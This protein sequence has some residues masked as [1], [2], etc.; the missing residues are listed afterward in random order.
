MKRWALSV[1]RWLDDRLGLVDLFGPSLTHLV[2][3]DATW[4]Y[5]FGSATLAAFIIQVVTGVALAFSYVPSS[6]PAVCG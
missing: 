5:V 1:W 6:A 3:R 4:W 2:P